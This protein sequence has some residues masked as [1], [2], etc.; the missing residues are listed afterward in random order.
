[1]A[2]VIR[3]KGIIISHDGAGFIWDDPVYGAE[4]DDVFATVEAAKADIDRIGAYAPA[5]VDNEI[6]AQ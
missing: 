6:V 5:V 1:M 3:Y 2:K 4:S